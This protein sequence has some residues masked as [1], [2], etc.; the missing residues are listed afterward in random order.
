MFELMDGY[1][2]TAIIKV[3]GV[4]GGGGNA[5]RRG[6]RPPTAAREVDADRLL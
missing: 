5:G 3:M 1:S 4:G 6:D 2:E